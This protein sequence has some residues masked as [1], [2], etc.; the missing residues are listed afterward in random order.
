[1]AEEK[2]GPTLEMSRSEPQMYSVVRLCAATLLAGSD[3]LPELIWVGLVRNPA[4]VREAFLVPASDVSR[5]QSW[6]APLLKSLKPAI[7]VQGTIPNSAGLLSFP[8]L[9]PSF[10]ICSWD[11]SSSISDLRD[12][13]LCPR[14]VADAHLLI[15]VSHV[16]TKTEN[17]PGS[18]HST[19]SLS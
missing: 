9:L 19:P 17:S 15:L 11:S 4:P 12:Q 10:L 6:A 5:Q 7:V 16:S 3:K 8:S 2:C 13:G 1:M 14:K 18:S